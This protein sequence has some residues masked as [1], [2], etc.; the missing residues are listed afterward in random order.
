MNRLKCDGLILDVDGTLWDSTG[1]CARSYSRVG[2]K[3]NGPDFTVDPEF[4]KT[5]FGRPMSEIIEQV[6]GVTDPERI[7]ALLEETT[8]LQARMLDEEPPAP[9]PG[10]KEMFRSISRVCPVFI[11][12]N[13]QAGYIEQFLAAAHVEDCVRDHL[14]PDDSGV[15]KAGNLQLIVQKHH[16]K[17]PVY[18]GDTALDEQ[19]CREAGVPF[20]YA[21]YGFGTADAPDTVIH[22]MDELAGVLEFCL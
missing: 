7:P 17:H 6:Y 4:L 8:A 2:A 5:L 16:L 14:C 21:A 18:V 13:C 19:S 15:L 12:S 1:V 10:V 3:I 22:S 20:I 9:Y 11:V